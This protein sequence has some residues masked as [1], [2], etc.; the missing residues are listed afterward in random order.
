MAFAG[1]LTT[2]YIHGMVVKSLVLSH[3]QVMHHMVMLLQSVP[4][5]LSWMQCTS[6]TNSAISTQSWVQYNERPITIG[7]MVYFA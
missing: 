6:S 5:D 4:C 3:H 7:D 2:E 1:L